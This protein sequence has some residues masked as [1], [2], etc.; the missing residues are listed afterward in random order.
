[1]SGDAAPAAPGQG[2]AA[3]LFLFTV[4]QSF[5]TSGIV[6][7]W[8]PLLM[9][10]KKEGVY[11]NRCPEG[12]E[13]CSDRDVALNLMFTIGAIANILGGVVGGPI[14]F[15]K[16][17]LAFGVMLVFVGSVTLAFADPHSE[18]A[19]PFA[20]VCQGLGGG[21]VH[22]GAMS[23]GYIF[24]PHRGYIMACLAGCLG[25]SSMVFQ[26]FNA[27]YNSG[28][29]RQAL[30]LVHAAILLF[31]AAGSLY[32]WPLHPFRAGD[33][34][35][36]EKGRM[37]VVHAASSLSAA[38]GRVRASWQQIYKAG[39]N[40]PFACFLV[41]L[42]CQ[43]LFSR[44]LMGMFSAE[45]DWKNELLEERGDAKLDV[46][47]HLTLFNMSQA[48]LGSTMIPMFGII[49]H[50]WGHRAGP[51]FATGVLSVVWL[52]CLLIP[53]VWPLY[54]MYFF[55]GW[56]RQF[57]FATFLNIMTSEYPPEVYGKLLPFVN[58]MTGVIVALQNP[59]LSFTLNDLD[60]NFYPMLIF[61]AVLAA[62]LTVVAGGVLV[63]ERRAPAAAAAA[64]AKEKEEEEEEEEQAGKVEEKKGNNPALEEVEE[65]AN[66]DDT[67][68]IPV[69]AA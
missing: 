35:A 28:V 6:Y 13:E 25:F 4:W 14:P 65:N 53:A 29:S 31:N 7:G 12:V 67:P 20:Y 64:A 33:L 68:P 52:G 26:I 51:A 36:Y 61:M 56:H 16:F 30:F 66:E 18:F 23:V 15:P 58:I 10:L 49:A 54:I 22:F 39:M 9:L 27:L 21:I 50:R 40:T 45:L 1:M 44:C 19:F 43:L 24:G 47:L 62:A 5:C 11:A 57:F 42:S 8:T 63:L 37:V 69:A 41:F 38:G 59:L 55:A 48:M 34:L 3:T 32:L 17:G 46:D 2:P 60:G